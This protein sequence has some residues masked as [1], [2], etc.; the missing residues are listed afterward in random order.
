V[1]VTAG[2]LDLASGS[3]LTVNGKMGI[4]FA[5]APTQLG[6]Y[7]GLRWAGDRVAALQGLTN[8]GA[9]TIN[10]G[11]GL[12]AYWSN[13]ASIYYDGTTYTYVG[14]NVSRIPVQGTIFSVF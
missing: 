4:V 7:W 1:A 10:N 2:G 11:P 13:R 9:L 3:A 8:S 6:P 14:F 12:P 5:G